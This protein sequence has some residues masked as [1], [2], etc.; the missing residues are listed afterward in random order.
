MLRCSLLTPWNR[1][2]VEY[3]AYHNSQIERTNL[4]GD[5]VGAG[6]TAAVGV[7]VGDGVGAGVGSWIQK[8]A[9]ENNTEA[10]KLA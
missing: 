8:S 4:V 2:T 6:V 7:T 5:G 3:S 9:D 1:I 10:S